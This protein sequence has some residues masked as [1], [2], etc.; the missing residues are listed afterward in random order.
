MREFLHVDDLANACIFFLRKKT[1]ETTINIGSG[2]EKTILQ[3]AK[4]IMSQLQLKFKIDFDL[5]KPDGTPR[6]I[7]DSSLAKKYGWQ[8]KINLISGLK[9]TYD[10]FLS[11]NLNY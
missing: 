7:V 11:Q 10:D 5:T 8:S 2:V 4:F 6:K 9:K 3:Y 1:S